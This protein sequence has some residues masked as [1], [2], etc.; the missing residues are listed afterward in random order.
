MTFP[1]MIESGKNWFG[2]NSW[3][4]RICILLR[5]LFGAT[6][7]YLKFCSLNYISLA[8]STII[9]LSSPIFVFIFARII[10]NESFTIFH[11]ISLLLSL[12]GIGFATKIDSIFLTSQQQ[13]VDSGNNMT[14]MSINN[15][16]NTNSITSST[17]NMMMMFH[18]DNNNLTSLKVTSNSTS[19]SHNPILLG[20]IYALS[21]TIFGSIV[22][23]LIRKVL[24]I[25]V[26]L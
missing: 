9:G 19:N 26:I 12:V 5:A 25:F 4:F 17:P 3:W 22:F 16:N 18:T 21:S 23:I 13:T 24:I 11:A 1:L 7:L 15:N 20:N 2:P 8:N 10:L 14:I 6:S